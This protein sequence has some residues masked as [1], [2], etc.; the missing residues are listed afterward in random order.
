MCECVCVCVGGGGLFPLF[1]LG[2]RLNHVNK[3]EVFDNELYVV[4]INQTT[5]FRY[6]VWHEKNDWLI[7]ATLDVTEL[8]WLRNYF[9][10]AGFIINRSQLWQYD[11][12]YMA[13]LYKI[14]QIDKDFTESKHIH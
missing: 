6:L 14:M 12:M 4:A 5:S 7:L 8:S 10:V 2:L 11:I 3:R 1:M 13:Y 9:S